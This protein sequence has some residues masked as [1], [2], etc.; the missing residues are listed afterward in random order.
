MG[1][2]RTKSRSLERTSY[3][4]TGTPPQLFSRFFSG[5]IIISRASF[6]LG[7]IFVPLSYGYSGARVKGGFPHPTLPSP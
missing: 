1:I 5:I 6:L 2:E 4:F 7:S 3:R